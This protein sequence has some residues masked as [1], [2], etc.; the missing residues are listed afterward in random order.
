MRPH[1]LTLALALGAI[2]IHRKDHASDR[3]LPGLGLDNHGIEVIHVIDPQD[4]E[5]DATTLHGP[6]GYT[7]DGETWSCRSVGPLAPSVI[8]SASSY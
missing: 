5:K 7:D 1:Q 3:E 8:L 2:A 4:E 6:G